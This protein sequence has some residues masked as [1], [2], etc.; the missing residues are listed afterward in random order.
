MRPLIPASLLFLSACGSAV[1]EVIAV[2]LTIPPELT[3]PCPISDRQAVTIRQLTAL[4]AEH[5][6][7]AQCANGRL[8]AIREIASED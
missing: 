2:P 6:W 1:P 5:L 8:A 7:S 3:E 4:A